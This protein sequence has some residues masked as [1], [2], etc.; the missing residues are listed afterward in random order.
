M[1]FKIS[2]KIHFKPNHCFLFL[3][4]KLPN[5]KV[6]LEFRFLKVVYKHRPSHPDVDSPANEARRKTEP[7]L[8]CCGHT[9]E[10]RVCDACQCEQLE[11]A[12]STFQSWVGKAVQHGQGEK[13]QNVFQIVQMGSEMGNHEKLIFLKLVNHKKF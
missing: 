5:N 11:S 10:N 3:Q 9:V 8:P 6:T 7:R 13:W 4:L 12:P 2:T 1:I